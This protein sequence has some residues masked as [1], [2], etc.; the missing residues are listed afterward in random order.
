MSATFFIQ[1]LQTFFFY[2]SFTFFNVFLNFYLNV[3]YICAIDYA[4]GRYLICS[5]KVRPRQTTSS[6]NPDPKIHPKIHLINAVDC[7][8]LSVKSF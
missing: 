7:F 3:Y 6:S 4:M 1:R 5:Y 2:T 8:R